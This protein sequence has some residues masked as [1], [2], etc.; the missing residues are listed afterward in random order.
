M[1]VVKNVLQVCS[2]FDRGAFRHPSFLE[3]RHVPIVKTGRIQRVAADV[4]PGAR[5]RAYVLRHRIDGNI[6]NSGPRATGVGGHDRGR[7]RPSITTNG[8]NVC[9]YVPSR[10]S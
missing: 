5:A 7:T 3:E 8:V 2:E 10:E 6:A 1:A 4:G 9:R